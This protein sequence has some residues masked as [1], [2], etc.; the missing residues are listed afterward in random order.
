MCIRDSIF[1][2][3]SALFDHVQRMPLAF[4]TSTQ[5][6]KLISRLN[7][8]VIGAQR[9]MTGT[10]GS[11]VSN[12]IIVVT[13][14]SAMIIIE[15]RLALLS[16]LLLPLFIVPAKRVGRTLQT[17]TR[18]GMNVNASMNATMNERFNVAGALLVK[19]YGRHEAEA[20]DFSSQ[21]GQVRD[22]GIR[23]AVYSRT[24]F[25]AL[26]LVGAIGTVVVYWLGAR[27]VI[28]DRLEVGRMVA[29]GFFVV[30]IYNPLT[31]LT[32]ARIC[33]LY[34][35]PSPRDATLSRMPSSA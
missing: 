1:D 10:L 8:D 34:T 25:V 15:W 22:I 35:S 6:G 14:L 32:N 19:L 30:R 9:A 13:T 24:F 20:S 18:D 5:T 29:M 3:R 28:S 33:L 16:L 26:T 7:N 21:A 23:S 17:I 31:A 4:F 2:L 11:V 12:V 27:L